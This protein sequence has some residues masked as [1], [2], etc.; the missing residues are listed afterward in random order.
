MMDDENEG[1]SHPIDRVMD[2][3]GVIHLTSL[4]LTWLGVNE[5]ER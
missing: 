3:C 4:D 2:D 5:F 1:I